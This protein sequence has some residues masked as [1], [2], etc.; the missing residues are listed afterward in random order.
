MNILQFACTYMNYACVLY[1]WVRALSLSYFYTCVTIFQRWNSHC[2]PLAGPKHVL[3]MS[4]LLAQAQELSVEV[5]WVWF[6]ILDFWYSKV[7]NFSNFNREDENPY[8]PQDGRPNLTAGIPI[9]RHGLTN[10]HAVRRCVLDI[11]CCIES[12]VS[13][14]RT[15]GLKL[16]QLGL[17]VVIISSGLSCSQPYW[18]GPIAYPFFWGGVRVLSTIPLYNVHFG[19]WKI[20]ICTPRVLLDRPHRWRMAGWLGALLQHAA[21]RSSEVDWCAA[22]GGIHCT[23]QCYLG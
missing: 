23:L 9:Q 12:A 5:S 11:T 17:L 19:H 1:T 10:S 7:G 2:W 3:Q 15:V 16:C 13:I 21:R 14:V 22:S 18:I 4:V 20:H 6:F 8:I